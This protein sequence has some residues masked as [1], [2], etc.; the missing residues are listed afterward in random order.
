MR[1]RVGS[2][3]P[4][5]THGDSAVGV[6]EQDIAEVIAWLTTLHDTLTREFEAID[7]AG[8]FRRDAWE[9]PEGGGGEVWIMTGTPASSA[10]S[11]VFAGRTPWP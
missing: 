7:G 5:R 9:R 1:R 4:G 8:T 11:A 10:A 3:G 6:T 2:C